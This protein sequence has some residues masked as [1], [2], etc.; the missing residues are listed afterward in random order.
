MIHYECVHVAAVLLHPP[1][2][3]GFVHFMLTRRT[4]Y[5]RWTWPS[6][7]ASEAPTIAPSA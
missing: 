6:G 3:A 1:I 7:L 2:S 4:V 5:I